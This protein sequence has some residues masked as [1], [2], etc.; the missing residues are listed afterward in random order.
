MSF[1]SP[2]TLIFIAV[3]FLVAGTVKGV[4]GFGLPTVTLA[5]LAVAIDL[6]VAIALIIVPM[7]LTNFWQGIVG[8]ETR[9]TFRRLWTLILAGAL[10]TW[11]ATD[12]LAGTDAIILATILGVLIAIYALFSL[13]APQLPAP[14]GHEIWL[15]PVMGAASGLFMGMTGSWVIPGVLYLQ[16]LRLP[17]DALVQG[18]GMAFSAST[19]V[20]GVALERHQL[21][22][23][24]LGVVSTG[25]LVPAFLG[26]FAGQQIRKRLP[27]ETFRRVFLIGLLL[28]GVYISLRPVIFP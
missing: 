18:M 21:L 7:F 5:I 14:E 4:I 23:F 24:E 15:S 13:L 12:I 3:A 10:A 25:A 6:K 22:N 9:A 26:M 8:K 1:T 17:R 11:F 19:L 2:E 27:E 28:L 16:A 20:M